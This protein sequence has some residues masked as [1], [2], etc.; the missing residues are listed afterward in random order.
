MDTTPCLLDNSAVYKTNQNE[1]MPTDS[2][3]KDKGRYVDFPI[4]LKSRASTT[5]EL[6]VLV[7]K[8]KIEKWHASHCFPKREIHTNS[9]KSTTI[10]K[11]ILENSILM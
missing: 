9:I 11:D 3:R 10:G 7:P 2:I 5:L 8:T 1:K 4:C 6:L